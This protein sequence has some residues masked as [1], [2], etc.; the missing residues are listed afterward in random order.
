MRSHLNERIVVCQEHVM[1]IKTI[2]CNSSQEFFEAHSGVRMKLSTDTVELHVVNLKDGPLSLETSVDEA[3][4]APHILKEVLSAKEEGCDAIVI[5]C[6]A[7]PVLRAARQITDLPVV[8]AGEASHHAA[9]MV[10]DK[11]SII[12][13]LHE[14]ISLFEENIQKYG[15]SNR[16]ASV[17]AVDL[18][19]LALDDYEA[20]F[21]ALYAES[22][23]AVKEDGAQAIVLGCTGMLPIRLRLQEK[24]WIP[25]V[26]PFTMGVQFAVAMVKG[27]LFSSPLS[28]GKPSQASMDILRKL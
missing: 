22:L 26:E 13:T 6:A 9:M 10:C 18:P 17:R 25:V 12:T 20:T 1:K 14:S 5:D 24:L 3:L 2:M 15:Y 19:V 4:A 7:D 11:F 28:Y 21:D 23:K 27:Q 16:L 8:S